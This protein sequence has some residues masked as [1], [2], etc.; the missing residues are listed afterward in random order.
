M[1][2]LEQKPRNGQYHIGAWVSADLK[3]QIMEL[4]R[5]EGVSVSLLFK[6]AF[7]AYAGVSSAPASLRAEVDTLKVQMAEV[8]RKLMG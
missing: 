4:A 8:Q 2:S 6:K 5:A 1:T 7:D 3:A